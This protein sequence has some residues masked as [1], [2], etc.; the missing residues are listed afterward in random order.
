MPEGRRPFRVI[1]NLAM[2]A[3]GKIAAARGP[4]GRLAGDADR[5]HMDLLRRQADAVLVGAATLRAADP[6]LAAARRPR[7]ATP[8]APTLWGLVAAGRRPLPADARF[9][10]PPGT[11]RRRVLVAACQRPRMAAAGLPAHV[12]LW[13]A[14]ERRIEPR[15]VLALLRARGAR[16]LL[17]EGGGETLWPFVQADLVDELFVTLAPLMLGGRGAPSPLGGDGLALPEA[18]QLALVAVRRRGDE[19]FCHWRR[20]PR[21]C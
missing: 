1:A 12:G 20:A 21:R 14:G 9:F 5:R 18:R 10:G 11:A 2:S 3:D 17:I 13:T 15:R 8:L 16:T 6:P 4:A 7:G 19:V